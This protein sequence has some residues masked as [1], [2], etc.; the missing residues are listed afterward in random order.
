MNNAENGADLVERVPAE[1]RAEWHGPVHAHGRGT[2]KRT[3]PRDEHRGKYEHTRIYPISPGTASF[4]RHC[5]LDLVLRRGKPNYIYTP[6]HIIITYL[7]RLEIRQTLRPSTPPRPNL[8]TQVQAFSLVVVQSSSKG[9][10]GNRSG[11]HGRCQQ[12]V[13]VEATR[14]TVRGTPAR[15]D[16]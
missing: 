11:R 8:P 4:T 16:S 9:A 12:Q 2:T 13:N 5:N 3:V 14:P 15:V 10:S 1:T 6:I 7:G